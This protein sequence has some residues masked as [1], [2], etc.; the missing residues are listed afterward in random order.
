MRFETGE[1]AQLACAGPRP[2]ERARKITWLW[3][4][5]RRLCHRLR[6]LLHRRGNMRLAALDFSVQDMVLRFGTKLYVTLPNLRPRTHSG[7]R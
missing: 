4:N 1:G 6:L 3:L 5:F 7:R 2:C